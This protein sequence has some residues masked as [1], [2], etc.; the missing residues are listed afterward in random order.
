MFLPKVKFI[1][2]PIKT[3]IDWIYGFLFKNEWGWG[4]VII[5]RHP[6]L[7]AIY[8]LRT[9]K[10]R[11]LFLEK[12]ILNFRKENKKRIMSKK[13]EIE[14]AWL[15]IEKKYLALLSEIIGMPWP[16]RRKEI[17]AMISINPI[18]PRF[19]RVWGF[20]LSFDYK[21]KD[22]IETIMHEICHFLY[23]E[24]WKELFPKSEKKTFDHPYIEWHLSELIAPVILNDKKIQKHLNQKAEFYN[25][26]KRIK[27][28]G[29]SAPVYFSKLYNSYLD[30]GGKIDDF[31]KEAYRII[32]KHK[33]LFLDIGKNV[34]I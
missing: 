15:S 10:E 17:K 32:K 4:K 2:I 31:I 18:C 11:I 16:S 27:I 34:K 23:F 6:G 3:E 22:A 5:R 9:E 8:K 13:K 33:K 14:T 25:E 7:K 19:L 20:S 30:K 21:I 12:Y 29:L 26:H 24:K 28:N 1:E